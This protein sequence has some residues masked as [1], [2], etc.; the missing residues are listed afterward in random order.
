MSSADSFDDCLSS[1]DESNE[2][3]IVPKTSRVQSLKL[4]FN[5]DGAVGK[6]CF[7]I[8]ATNN[9]FPVDYIPTVFDN[10][11]LN[12]LSRKHSVMVSAGLWDTFG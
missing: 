6:T 4:L 7:L 8:R 5:G 2:T 9:V 10:Y 12:L 11:V 1:D 3:P